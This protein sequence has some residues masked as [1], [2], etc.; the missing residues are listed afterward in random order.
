MRLFCIHGIS[1]AFSLSINIPGYMRVLFS[2]FSLAGLFLYGK[3][4]MAKLAP[5]LIVMSVSV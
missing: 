1:Q 4:E 5:E 3:A 2:R